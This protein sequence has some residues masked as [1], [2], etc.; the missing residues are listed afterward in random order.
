MDYRMKLKDLHTNLEKE[1]NL[2]KFRPKK[3]ISVDSFW[4]DKKIVLDIS[5]KKFEKTIKF[6]KDSK[7]K[8]KKI[9]KKNRFDALNFSKRKLNINL[10]EE[11]NKINIKTFTD[12]NK[13]KKIFPTS[14][15][16]SFKDNYNLIFSNFF[17]K[18][19]KIIIYFLI[20]I[21]VVFIDKL[22]VEYFTN[23]WYK[24]LIL[25]KNNTQNINKAD[26]IESSNLDFKIANILFLPFKILPWNKINNASSAILW[27]V[28][29]T[30]LLLN[31]SDFI[32]KSNNF[33]KKK[34]EENIAYSQLLDNSKD[35]FIYSENEINNIL[36]TYNKIQFSD[37]ILLKNKLDYFKSEL[38]KIW[39]YIH[40]VNDNFDTFLDILWHNK[41]K[42]YL[43][44]FQN[45]DEIRPQWGFMWSMWILEI[46]RWQIK[47]FEK[48]DVYD[49]EF[50][51]KKEQFTKEIAPEWINKMT[52]KL[53]LRDSNYYIND[54][55]S[56]EKIKFFIKKAWYDIDW[57]IYINQNTLFEILDLIWEY[58][59]KVLNTKINSSNF[60]IVM[61]SLVESKK[62]HIW[63]LWTPKQVLFDFMEEFKK[64]LEEKNI[65][66]LD[67]IKI[68]FSDI[69]NREIK[70]YNFNKQERGLLEEL[71]IY[72]PIK[73]SKS[74][75]FSYPVF[76]SISWNKSDRYIKINYKKTVKKWEN[77]SYKTN[78]EINL[79]HTFNDLELEKNK[80]IFNK[81][82]INKDLDKLLSI[83]WNWTNK[84]YVRIILPKNAIIKNNNIISI[85]KYYKR[86]KVIDFYLN[87]PVWKKSNFQIE[88]I[89]PN[90]QCQTYNYKL[91][92]QPWIREYN[93]DLNIFWEEK[94]FKNL[95]SDLFVN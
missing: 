12:N 89:I 44:V 72:N 2:L 94:I 42:K 86:W 56:S 8:I 3:E 77:C 60:S 28:Q 31:I 51:I 11:E 36:E 6:K 80:K 58:D 10:L 14:F 25:L 73:Y 41:R 29:T 47:S 18:I 65:N 64:V 74:L 24:K 26:L 53:G 57:I 75:D 95:K 79:E 55:D 38:K 71:T 87:T 9:N 62:S 20:F 59:S 66:K 17:N 35:I 40:T 22:A 32:E 45:N 52:P 48:K 30:N 76:T 54:R 50:K 15:L 92:K 4:V 70:F 39:F 78:L 5:K 33:I 68:I 93:L 63:S 91:Y 82:W 81:F 19:P 27:G 88:Y 1:I 21:L 7:L 90:I 13:T 85:K 43:I 83:Q 37:N 61:S 16:N 23:S 34:W 69:K 67:L 46:F 49:Y 84:Q